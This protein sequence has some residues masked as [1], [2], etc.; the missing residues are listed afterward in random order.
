MQTKVNIISNYIGQGWSVII[1]LVSVPLYIKFIGIEAYGLVGFSTLLISLSNSIFDFGF[2]S[3]IN[4]ELARR[5][6]QS[7]NVGD[8]R[9]F[10]R[11]LELIYWLIGLFVGVIVLGCSP[12]IASHWL[13]VKLLPI[14][15]VQRSV[16]LMGIIVIAQWPLTFY[17]GGLMG[18][19]R[20]VQLNVIN[21]SMNTIRVLGA[22]LILWLI[23]SSII[24]FFIWQVIISLLQV[25]ITLLILWQNLPSSDHSPRIDL[26]QIKKILRFAAGVSATSLVTFSLSQ[27]DKLFV[28][29]IFSL[30]IFGYYTLAN[31]LSNALR[32]ASSPIY[33]AIFPRFAKLIAQNK[34]EV[35]KI[36]YHKSCQLVATIVMPVMMVFSFFSYNL[37]LLWTGNEVTAR[38]SAPIASIL[39]LG[40]GL[41]AITGLP[42]ELQIAYGWTKLGFYK[43]LIAF[44]LMV[45]LILFLIPRYGASGA[46]LP[47]IFLNLGYVLVEIPIMHKRVL[48][49]EMGRWYREDVLL[50]LVVATFIS[51]VGRILIPSN[52]SKGMIILSIVVIFFTTF[53][54]TAFSTT[55]IRSWI[56]IQIALF[57]KKYSLLDKRKS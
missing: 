53:G 19:E 1:G 29:K 54:A 52:L 14:I 56:L 42:Y 45:P 50:P 36:L 43:N 39:I 10:V 23:S 17:Q 16:M 21:T 49:G 32:M 20:Q 48:R 25:F 37:I 6:T 12:F 47:W 57:K 4:R 27:M 3:T 24:S 40:T 44:F 30:E 15:T 9:D 22:I 46:A 7:Q 38:F 2:S 33:N 26:G 41:N 55:F 31:T 34:I 51:G 11:T 28:S 5:Y 13:N 18:L 35:V 8:I